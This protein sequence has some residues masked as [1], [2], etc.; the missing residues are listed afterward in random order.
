MAQEDYFRLVVIL[1][2][3]F[4]RIVTM[5]VSQ[6][7]RYTKYGDDVI[8]YNTYNGAL[9]S[10]NKNT[11][12]DEYNNVISA[13]DK[14]AECRALE[15]KKYSQEFLSNF[16]VEDDVDEINVLA[17]DYL[18]RCWDP[19]NLYF[20][21]V[22]NNFC[23]FKCAYCYET[24]DKQ[25]FSASA[26]DNLYQAIVDYHSKVNLKKIGIE[27]YGGEPL[28]SKDLIL[29]F[30]KKLNSFCK[31][32]DIET[33]YAITTNG[34]ELTSEVATEFVELGI[35]SFQITIDG[36][37]YLH[38]KLRPLKNGS[39]T[40]SKI[41]ENLEH[42]KTLDKLFHVII[43]VN[44]TYETLECFDEF[45]DYFESHFDSSRFSLFFHGISDWGGDSSD[46]EMIVDESVKTYIAC[47]LIER[48][49][50]RGINVTRFNTAYSRYGRV[51]Y[52]SIPNHFVVSSD[53]KLRKCT[54][55]M[56]EYDA[57]N[58][59]GDIS[60]GILNIDGFKLANFAAP[61][62]YN[63]KCLQCD[64]LPI[65]MNM[66]C[67]KTNLHREDRE[68]SMDKRLVDKVYEAKYRLAQDGN[69]SLTTLTGI[70]Y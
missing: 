47:E 44:Y 30:T 41:I 62:F 58:C 26:L 15:T 8:V 1:L 22:V 13:I 63:Q 54:F 56:P 70:L 16:C 18:A 64:I 67:P 2:I 24:H 6:Y 10:L 68:C 9:G 45:L 28:L 25:Q 17:A 66:S 27:W 50:K 33:I 37:E 55:D 21:C 59:V 38:N 51:C 35:T 31:M 53:E 46:S 4:E 32:N 43:R 42:M 5:K 60:D 20:I 69:L 52:A 57:F 29:S 14:K 19:Q 11:A 40:W 65:C 48:T 61:K 3:N 36:A 7:T 23:N 49:I 12:T 34:Y 39:G